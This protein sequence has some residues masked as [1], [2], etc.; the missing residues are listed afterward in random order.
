MNAPTVEPMATA[1]G[2][3]SWGELLRLLGDRRE[4]ARAAYGRRW[5]A[6]DVA[7][8]GAL[9]GLARLSGAGCLGADWSGLTLTEQRAIVAAAQRMNRL[10]A[11]LLA[12]DA[13]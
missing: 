5:D 11:E 2:A 3:R 7:D 10:T 8:R 13:A 1:K 6:M 4:T 9:L 12:V